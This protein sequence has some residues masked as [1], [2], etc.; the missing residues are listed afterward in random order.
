LQQP[1]SYLN[2]NNHYHTLI[3]TTIIIC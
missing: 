2:Y 3:V 1:L